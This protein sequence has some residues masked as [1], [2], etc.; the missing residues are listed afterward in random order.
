MRVYHFLSE[1]N[2]IDDLKNRR[3]KISRFADMNDPFEL[4]AVE[5]SDK[6][7][8]RAFLRTRR[9]I[10]T[11]YGVICFSRA[12]SNPVLWSHYAEKHRGVCL[13][14]DIPDDLAIHV[15][16]NGERLMRNVIRDFSRGMLDE[17]FMI[18]LLGTKYK[19][20]EYED[21]VRVF[22]NLKKRDKEKGQY[23]KG[24]GEDLTLRDVVLGA[25]WEG[26]TEEIGVLL[27]KYMRGIRLIQA[28][29]AFRSFRIVENKAKTNQLLN[30]TR[31]A[32]RLRSSRSRSR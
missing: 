20:W 12:W 8:R 3:I 32:D 25:R 30:I 19:D 21:E 31:R 14:F 16:Y 27:G 9:Q 17:K 7:V 4:L 5:L 2:A 23:F 11:K 6:E 18:K 26:E 29:L 1:A 28:R 22:A 13:G 10:D 15:R 24:F